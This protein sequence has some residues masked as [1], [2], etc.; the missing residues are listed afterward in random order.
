MDQRSLDMFNKLKSFVM[1]TGHSRSGHS[2]IGALLDAHPYIR[3]PHEYNLAYRYKEHIWETQDTLF[4]HLLDLS[5][6][7]AQEGRQRGPGGKYHVPGMWQGKHKELQIIG[8][9]EGPANA[10]WFGKDPVFFDEMITKI[11]LPIKFVCVYRNPYDN[12]TTIEKLHKKNPWRPVRNLDEAIDDYFW[13]WDMNVHL[14]DQVEQDP[15]CDMLWIKQENFVKR[16]QYI[17]RRLCDF[18]DIPAS[19]SYIKACSSIVFQKPRETRYN[20]PWTRQQ[21][22]RVKLLKQQYPWLRKY[23]Y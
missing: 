13:Y 2:I 4:K 17:L 7:N 6:N 22:H 14:I 21:I 15:R 16:P 1:F 20:Y 18:L 3:I 12:I 19:N 9:K 10:Y 8:D 11:N 5:K 23:E